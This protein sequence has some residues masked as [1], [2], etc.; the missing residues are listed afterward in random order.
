[1]RGGHAG[2]KQPIT[3]PLPG[4]V[5]GAGLPVALHLPEN[6]KRVFY[7]VKDPRSPSLDTSAVRVSHTSLRS[8]PRRS[9]RSVSRIYAVSASR[10]M[11]KATVAL[12]TPRHLA[13][14]LG[15]RWAAP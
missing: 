10:T 8:V 3:L 15:T 5:Y 13:T 9:P 1:L 7:E 2:G 11:G 4:R 12:G 14:C 6:S